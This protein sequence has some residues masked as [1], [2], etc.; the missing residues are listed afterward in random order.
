MA[1]YRAALFP[2]VNFIIYNIRNILAT[3]KRKKALEDG[4]YE[5]QFDETPE[6]LRKRMLEGLK[7]FLDKEE[8]ERKGFSK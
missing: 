1:F 3:R 2:Q 5:T 8:E 7:E 4:T 6:E